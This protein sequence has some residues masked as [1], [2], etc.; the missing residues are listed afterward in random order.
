MRE[1]HLADAD[2]DMDLDLKHLLRIAEVKVPATDALLNTAEPRTLV[3]A[4]D[5][6]LAMM[7]ECE[8]VA[9]FRLLRHACGCREFAVNGRTPLSQ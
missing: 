8:E 4:I 2:A 7:R 1:F 9:L 5:S 6:I 3:N